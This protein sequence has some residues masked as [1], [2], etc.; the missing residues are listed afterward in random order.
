MPLP[1]PNCGIR[2]CGT[3]DR[4]EDP[5]LL[6]GFGFSVRCWFYFAFIIFSLVFICDSYFYSCFKIGFLFHF[7]LMFIFLRPPIWSV[8]AFLKVQLA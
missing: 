3:L 8:V 4:P 1:L 6:L 7:I 2:C 5:T